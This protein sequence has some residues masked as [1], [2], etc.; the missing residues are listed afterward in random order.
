MGYGVEQT[1][2]LQATLDAVPADVVLAATPI[3]LTRVLSLNKPVVRVRY[4]LEET[5]PEAFAAPLRRI[6]EQ[7]GDKEPVVAG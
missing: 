3:D 1:H 5:D 2:E 7:A 4:D 6:M